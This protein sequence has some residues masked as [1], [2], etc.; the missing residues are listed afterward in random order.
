[1]AAGRAAYQDFCKF[2][3]GFRKTEMQAA[4]SHSTGVVLVEVAS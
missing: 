4:T 3:V 2:F 1:M